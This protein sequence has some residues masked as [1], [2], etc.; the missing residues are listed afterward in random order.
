[1]GY[2]SYDNVALRWIRRALGRTS[3]KP[4]TN[5]RMPFQDDVIYSYG[6]HFEIARV[7]RDH[8][9]A[10]RGVLINGD[11]FSNTTSKHQSA[12]RFAIA[13]ESDRL[14]VVTIPH[15]VLSEASI[16]VESVEAIDVQR[17]WNTQTVVRSV[18]DPG[19]WMADYGVIY[20]DDGGWQNSLTGE[21][22]PRPIGSRYSVLPPAVDCSCE[23]YEVEPRYTSENW[24]EYREAQD[25]RN[26]H[27]RLHHGEWEEVR[28]SVRQ[29]GR[30][31]M[32]S[33]TTVWEAVADDSVERGYVFER[34]VHRHWLGASLIKAKVDYMTNAR[35]GSCSGT[36]RG[37]LDTFVRHGEKAIGPLTRE[38]MYRHDSV[39]T[40][41][42]NKA[43]RD[44]VETPVASWYVA[45]TDYTDQCRGCSG[46][47]HGPQQRQR[48]AY[49][50]SGFDNN[51]A[52]VSYF[53]CELAPGARPTTVEEALESLKP[54]PVLLAEQSGR[55]VKRQGDI[56]AIPMPSL[57]TLELKQ[58]GGTIRKMPK[59]YTSA[60]AQGGETADVPYVLNTN[61]AAS[62]VI[63]IGG[64]TYG[65]GTLRHLP[66]WRA[67]DHARLTLGTQWHL[68]VK[69]T[70][71]VAS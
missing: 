39:H 33:G 36:G 52:R 42:T 46:R 50:L 70:V 66:A 49:F 53:F 51:E 23:G 28:A 26:T 31:V 59:G 15:S 30:V 20:D 19:R 8:K 1:M 16:Q 4:L 41:M 55:E 22:L 27:I 71:P 14:P 61:H 34:T 43:E 62:E 21:F 63:V 69:N 17:D 37:A 12:V 24:E 48:T 65:R 25:A 68:L 54:E 35:C 40:Y 45:A 2:N 67:A 58:R 10:P 5:P 9:G 60:K 11:T 47:G 32:R 57:T 6:T 38:E 7:L 18:E 3:D 56:Y 44:G 29:T 64:L 13:R